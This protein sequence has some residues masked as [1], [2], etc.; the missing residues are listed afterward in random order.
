MAEQQRAARGAPD[1]ASAAEVRATQ[2]VAAAKG[3]INR[4]FSGT[5]LKLVTA[6]GAAYLAY[7]MWKRSEE[8]LPQPVGEA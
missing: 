3:A 2:K 4:S 6:G 8:P 1:T 5:L 7:Y